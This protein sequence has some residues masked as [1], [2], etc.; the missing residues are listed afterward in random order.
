MQRNFYIPPGGVIGA[1]CNTQAGV[2]ALMG[3]FASGGGRAGR[4][5]GRRLAKVAQRTKRRKARTGKGSP[6][7]KRRMARLRAMQKRR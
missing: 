1:Q 5:A 3:G 4:R 6:A 7:M 2:A